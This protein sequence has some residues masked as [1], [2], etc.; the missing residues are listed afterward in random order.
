MHLLPLSYFEEDLMG[1]ILTI[2]FQAPLW[3][4]LNLLFLN[5]F[6]VVYGSGVILIGIAL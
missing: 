2:G 5:P 4:D 6:H 3:P 1:F